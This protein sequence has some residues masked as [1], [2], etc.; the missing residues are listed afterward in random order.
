MVPA[1][2]VMPG[3]PGLALFLL[4][5]VFGGFAVVGQPHV[6]IRFMLL[7]GDAS[8]ARAKF[9]YYL[10]FT[11]FYV[12]AVAVGMLARIYLADTQSFDAELALPTMAMELLPPV[13][14]GLIL[15]GVFAATMSTAD[16]LV[17]S[18]SSAI[19]HDIL[20]H[21]IERPVLLK[22]T[23]VLITLV[24]LGLALSDNQS[25]FELVL[26]SWSGMACAFAPM[27]LALCFGWRP[28]E[29]MCLLSMVV[30][31]GTMMLWR[32]FGLQN[33]IYETLP[34]ILAG[35]AVLAV[36]RGMQQ[37]SQNRIPD[38]VSASR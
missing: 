9:W 14:V 11:A 8:I 23:T 30:G 28:G 33:A 17:L 6:M 34:G 20:P 37:A 36:W 16:S 13:L 38:A 24:A 22:I 18:C 31:F 5:W 21:N 15:A 7:D 19:T 4:S 29:W 25:V 2:A 12:M 32:Y 10:W 26:L 27:L 3:W 35:V 1:D